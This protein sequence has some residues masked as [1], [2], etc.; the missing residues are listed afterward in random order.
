MTVG[1]AKNKQAN[2]SKNGE[3]DVREVLDKHEIATVQT[4]A[5]DE[6]GAHSTDHGARPFL[7]GMGLIGSHS[8]N[9]TVTS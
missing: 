6:A 8:T 2:I 5:I 1:F 9:P 7:R 3:R 4:T